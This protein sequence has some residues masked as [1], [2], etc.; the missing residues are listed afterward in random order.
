MEIIGDEELFLN[1]PR[2]YSLKCMSSF[3]ILL[4]F[5]KNV[6]DLNFF[7]FIF[8]RLFL[9]NFGM[10]KQLN[11]ISFQNFRYLKKQEMND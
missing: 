8:L 2:K 4:N 11:I 5:S 3:G 9:N 6:I 1:C 10:K 7:K